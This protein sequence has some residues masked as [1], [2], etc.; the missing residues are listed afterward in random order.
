MVSNAQPRRFLPSAVIVICVGRNSTSLEVMSSS[1][2][3][4]L[5]EL[6][7]VAISASRMHSCACV[8]S[9]AF[10]WSVSVSSPDGVSVTRHNCCQP[11]HACGDCHKIAQLA[12][13]LWVF[14]DVAARLEVSPLHCNFSLCL[15]PVEQRTQCSGVLRG[16]TCASFFAILLLPASDTALSGLKCHRL[17]RPTEPNGLQLC[18]LMFDLG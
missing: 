16:A 8:V 2:D 14:A 10:M 18:S 17:G 12:S 4:K 11:L 7:A 1:T 13:W 6:R 3:M 5:S 15:P 9:D